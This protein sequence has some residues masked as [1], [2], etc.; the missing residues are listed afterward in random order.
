M[1]HPVKMVDAKPLRDLVNLHGLSVQDISDRTD[2][3][4][5]ALHGYLRKGKMPAHMIATCR[6]VL[7]MVKGNAAQQG[8][9]AKTEAIIVRL[10]PAKKEEI[11]RVLDALGAKYRSLDE[12]E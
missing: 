10:P 2:I 4:R 6:G 12:I 5:S 1:G 9:V 11:R 3:S 8:A 7:S